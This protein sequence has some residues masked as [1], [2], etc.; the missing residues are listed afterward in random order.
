LS[1]SK[2]LGSPAKLLQVETSVK[3]SM[4]SESSGKSAVRVTGTD[5]EIARTLGNRHV[6]PA[7][8]VKITMR[9]SGV[10]ILIP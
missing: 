3:N 7:Y 6:R 9:L 2:I 5:F 10:V 8:S 4:S 1:W